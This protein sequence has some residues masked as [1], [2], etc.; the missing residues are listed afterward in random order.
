MH[1]TRS[2]KFAL[3]VDDFGVKYKNEEDIEHFKS[4]LMAVNPETGKPMFEMSTD[5]KGS[6]FIG[7]TLD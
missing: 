5:E 1:E 6:R 3:V 4:A 7:L 2:I